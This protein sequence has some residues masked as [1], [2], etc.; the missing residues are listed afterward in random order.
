MMGGLPGF[1]ALDW[2]GTVVPWFGQPPFEGALEFVRELQA[3]GV[4]I[5]VVSHAEPS[6]IEA[7]VSRVGLKADEVCGTGNKGGEFDRLQRSRGNGL[8]IGDTAMDLRAALGAGMPFLQARLEG[9]PM[10]EM[11]HG[12]INDWAEAP[13]ILRSMAGIFTSA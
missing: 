2:N 7:D 9:Q 1:L 4:H 8:A 5:C 12:C 11:A 10:M 6:Q 3:A 13:I